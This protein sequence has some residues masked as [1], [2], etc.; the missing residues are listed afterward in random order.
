MLQGYIYSIECPISGDIKYIGGTYD[1]K[2]RFRAHLQIAKRQGSDKPIYLWMT[3]LLHKGIKPVFNI[4]FTCELRRKTKKE[5]ET[6][7][8]YLPL[9]TLLNIRLNA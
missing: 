8:M 3:D 5:V 2:E 6:I 9:G 7:K 4:L 1:P